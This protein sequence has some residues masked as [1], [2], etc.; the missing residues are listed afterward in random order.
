M[1]ENILTA[2]VQIVSLNT[3]MIW[4]TPEGFPTV[5]TNAEVIDGDGDLLLVTN[6]WRYK[7]ISA[8]QVTRIIRHRAQETI[9]LR[10]IEITEYEAASS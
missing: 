3:F 4:Y 6:G 8:Q 1:S 9:E 10:D 7:I 5:E 2:S